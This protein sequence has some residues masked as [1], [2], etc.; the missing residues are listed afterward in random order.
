[1]FK[2]LLVISLLLGL[3]FVVQGF[4][5]V[6]SAPDLFDYFDDDS[7]AVEEDDDE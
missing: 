6:A 5:E 7:A 3:F 1:M 2:V 4:A